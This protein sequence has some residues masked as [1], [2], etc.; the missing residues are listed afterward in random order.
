MNSDEHELKDQ[1]VYLTPKHYITISFLILLI[2]MVI[3]T[4]YNLINY[5]QIGPLQ[6]EVQNLKKE[7]DSKDSQNDALK[8]KLNN[9]DGAYKRLLEKEKSPVT[10][11]PL[12]GDT[13]IG[14]MIKFRWDY[15]YHKKYQ[16]YIIEIRCISGNNRTNRKYDVAIPRQEIMTLPTAELGNGEFIWRIIPGYMQ[17]DQEV[18]QGKP[19]NYSF[20]TVYKST[21]DRIRETKI[22]RVGQTPSF[23]GSFTSYGDSGKIKGFDVDLINWIAPKLAS[24]LNIKEKIKCKIVKLPWADLLPSLAKHEIDLVITG[25]TSTRAREEEFSGI[26]FT[27]GYY[28]THEVFVSLRKFGKRLKDLEILKGKKVGVAADTTNEQVANFLSSKYGFTVNNTFKSQEDLVTG[29]Q[30]NI[31]QFILMDDVLTTNSHGM[32]LYQIGPKLDKLLT[33]FYLDKLGRTKE[34]YA[35][36]VV[37]EPQV[38]PNLLTLINNILKT[39]EAKA[40]LHQLTKTWIKNKIF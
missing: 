15:L 6:K 7:V 14:G 17:K 16:K 11:Q 37:E 30:N 10:M 36:A 32:I 24:E 9:V 34:M 22:L 23:K 3:T 39:S 33:D 1:R 28:Q 18:I 27:E 8:D 25:M 2:T 4:T 38:G 5:L 19:S 13:V 31:I 20:F 26:K 35:I 40:K 12:D 21:V 29:L